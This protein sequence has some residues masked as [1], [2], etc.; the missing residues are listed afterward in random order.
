VYV[1]SLNHHRRHLTLEA[2]D[3]AIA[4]LLKSRPELSDRQIAEQTNSSPTTVG[5][6]RKRLEKPGMVSRV[7]TRTD[8]RGVHQPAHK[9]VNQATKANKEP[10]PVGNDVD[11]EASADQRKSAIEDLAL[12]GTEST[13]PSSTETPAAKG[14]GPLLD[15]WYRASPDDRRRFLKYIGAVFVDTLLPVGSDDLGIPGFDRRQQ[16]AS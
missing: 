6:K 7:D 3:R 9:R 8:K 13:A 1:S 10:K 12:N 14:Y 15:A 5:N 4:D 2:K 11:P 16:V